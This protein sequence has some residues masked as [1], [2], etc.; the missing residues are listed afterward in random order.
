MK[1]IIM[2]L[3]ALM[4]ATNVAIA[5]QSNAKLLNKLGYRVPLT[6]SFP[7]WLCRTSYYSFYKYP[8]VLNGYACG[9]KVSCRKVFN[10]RYSCRY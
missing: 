5:E 7:W 9:I 2:L 1:K 4:L 10:N 6:I 3:L 8:N